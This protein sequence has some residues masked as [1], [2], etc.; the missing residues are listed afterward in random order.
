MAQYGDAMK[1]SSSRSVVEKMIREM[2]ARLINIEI[3]PDVL[4]KLVP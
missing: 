3:G 4:A 1:D 2:F